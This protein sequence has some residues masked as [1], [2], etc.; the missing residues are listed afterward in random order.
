MSAS[1]EPTIGRVRESV[2]SPEPDRH[3]IADSATGSRCLFYG[4]AVSDP[5]VHWDGVNGQEIFLHADC[6]NSFA[7]RI[8]RDAHE[9]QNPRFALDYAQPATT[10]P[11]T[12]P[13]AF[14]IAP[15]SAR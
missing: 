10:L 5:A 11:C 6:T 14:Q 2:T 3:G 4:E 1:E 13:S 9:I 8:L 15:M 12:V 7:G